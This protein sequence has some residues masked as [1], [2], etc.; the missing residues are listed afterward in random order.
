MMKA[1]FSKSKSSNPK[2]RKKI[3]PKQKC[4]SKNGE[5]MKKEE[6]FSMETFF[7]FSS[8]FFWWNKKQKEKSLFKKR[9]NQRDKNE[10][11]LIRKERVD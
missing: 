9:K 2:K 4:Y 1:K 6:N 7:S 8:S 10:G 11:E 5:R 3:F